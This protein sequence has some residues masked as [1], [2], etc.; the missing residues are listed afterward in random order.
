MGIGF[1][2]PV[3]M[4]KTIYDQLRKEGHVTRGFLGI[5]IQDVTKELA[6]SFGLEK[7]EGILVSQVQPD[8]AA[9]D[10]GLRSG[11]V[12]LE[13]DGKPVE[14]VDKFRNRIALSPAGT[15]LKLRVFRKGGLADLTIKVGARKGEGAA[16]SNR[17]LMAELGFR[18]QE[19]D[20]SLARRLGVSTLDGVVVTEVDPRSHAA[21]QGLRP[22]GVITEVNRQPVKD[23]ED[24]QRALERSDRGRILILVEEGGYGRYVVVSREK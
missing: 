12:I 3:N 4:I 11:D 22:G 2:I 8:G 16:V 7:T 13:V 15:S 21:H 23:L 18:V 10:S 24:F 14:P 20:A 5:M 1:A 6:E 19:L 9:A 17:E